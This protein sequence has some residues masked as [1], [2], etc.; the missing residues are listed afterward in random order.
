VS[1]L[2][3]LSNQ[4]A[5]LI[6]LSNQ[7]TSLI[8]LSNQLKFLLQVLDT[9]SAIL[10]KVSHYHFN[11]LGKAVRPRIVLAAAQAFNFDEDGR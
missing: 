4:L 7:L 9:K 8:S 1:A 10:S 11:G 6:S 2:Y 3:T 5:S